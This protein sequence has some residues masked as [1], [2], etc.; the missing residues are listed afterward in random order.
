M[1]SSPQETAFFFDSEISVGGG[2]AA[3]ALACCTV[4]VVVVPVP[5]GLRFD[6]IVTAV[7]RDEVDALFAYSLYLGN[8]RPEAARHDD[9][10]PRGVCRPNR[11]AVVAGARNQRA[12]DR[13][14]C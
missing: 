2:A 9:S 4:V 12:R 7:W 6:A 10:D 1:T 3:A 11:R 5:A 14:Y 8:G 13:N